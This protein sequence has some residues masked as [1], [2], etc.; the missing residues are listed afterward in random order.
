MT[1][2]VTVSVEALREDADLD[3]DDRNDSPVGDHQFFIDSDHPNEAVAEAVAI[4]RALDQF[5]AS[6]PI[7]LLE[8][9]E[10][11]AHLSEKSA[12]EAGPG[13]PE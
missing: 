2:E 10:I 1:Y 3:W 6:V 12:A 13:T 9:F 7:A 11:D 4:E 8:D 5:H